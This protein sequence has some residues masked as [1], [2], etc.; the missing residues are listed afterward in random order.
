MQSMSTM[1]DDKTRQNK[2]RCTMW[3][4]RQCTMCAV[5]QVTEAHEIAI[6]HSKMESRPSHTREEGHRLIIVALIITAYAPKFSLKDLPYRTVSDYCYCTAM[7][8]IPSAS[9]PI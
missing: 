9:M 4:L 1:K 3:A 6:H 5:R 7:I 8:M 2:L